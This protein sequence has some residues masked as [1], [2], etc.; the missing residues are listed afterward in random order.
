MSSLVIKSI[1]K[2]SIMGLFAMSSY[3]VSAQE[4]IENQLIHQAIEDRIAKIQVI[5]EAELIQEI[6]DQ[7]L[8][9]VVYIISKEQYVSK[10]LRAGI[11]SVYVH[12]E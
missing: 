12:D 9:G 2:A 5:L 11:Q 4:N 8:S 1:V 3:V 6:H 10:I 7:K